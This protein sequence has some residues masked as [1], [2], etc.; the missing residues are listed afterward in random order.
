MKEF[1]DTLETMKNN[2]LNENFDE[3]EFEIAIDEIKPEILKI[4]EN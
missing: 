1:A 4:L 3:N 2:T